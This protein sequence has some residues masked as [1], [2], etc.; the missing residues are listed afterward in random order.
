FHATDPGKEWDRALLQYVEGVRK[1]PVWGL[2][3]LDFHKEG[4]NSWSWLERGQTVFLAAEKS[5]AA[6]LDAMRYGRMYAVY[7]GGVGKLRLNEFTLLSQASGVSRVSGETLD[8]RGEAMGIRTV[9]TLSE[10]P[11]VPI[12]VSLIDSG[13]ILTIIEGE[14]PLNVERNF[15]PSRTQ[16][17]IRLEVSSPNHRIISNP[18]FYRD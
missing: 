13:K 15:F 16:G 5:R 11:G 2:C 9:I 12:R 6:V 10:D 3:G 18:I 14:T 8:A 1:R 17:Y 7:Q 4:M